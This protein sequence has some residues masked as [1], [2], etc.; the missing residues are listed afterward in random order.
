[1]NQPPVGGD[2]EAIELSIYPDR[3]HGQY[4][5][6][7]STTFHKSLADT[8]RFT[9]TGGANCGGRFE[10]SQSGDPGADEFVVDIDVLF[11]AEEAL[12]DVLVGRLHPAQ[13]EYGVGIY[14]SCIYSYLNRSLLTCHLGVQT[15]DRP[16][17]YDYTKALNFGVH[18][19]LPAPDDSAD[20]PLRI[21][22]LSTHMPLFSHHLH[23]LA[24]SVFFE[25]VA[26]STNN[27]PIQVEV[28]KPYHDSS[29]PLRRSTVLGR[30]QR[31][32]G[33]CK[34]R[35]PWNVLSHRELS[36]EEQERSDRPHRASDE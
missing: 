4:H 31:L 13:G 18:L 10:I 3:L 23:E 7:G 12:N 1:M 34:R 28:R 21:R 16:I 14:V 27:A 22:N 6:H 11:R 17:T 32:L 15:G 9:S 33:D 29:R 19:R 5:A 2:F 35:N 36:S 25:R 20:T 24:T 26:L 8:L 30:G